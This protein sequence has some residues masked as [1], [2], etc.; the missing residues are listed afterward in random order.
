MAREVGPACRE[1]SVV[2]EMTR[3]IRARDYYSNVNPML[4]TEQPTA[5]PNIVHCQVC[6]QDAP[7]ETTRYGDQP[8]RQCRPHTFEVRILRAGFVVR[9]LP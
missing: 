9:D 7:Y 4:V 8:V 3:D 2:D 1:A 6:V 5:E